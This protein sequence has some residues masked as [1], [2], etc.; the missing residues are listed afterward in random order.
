LLAV[1]AVLT[2]STS[3]ASALSVTV[4]SGDYLDKIA[5][6]HNTTWQVLHDK[7]TDIPDPNLIYPGQIIQIPELNEVVP[8]RVVEA[9][10]AVPEVKVAPTP[11]PVPETVIERPKTFSNVS[12]NGYDPGQC[13]WYVKNMRPDLPNNL[14]DA[15]EWY[16]NAQAQGLSVGEVPQAGAAAPRK[17]G[18]HVVYVHSVN[19]D[20]TITI[21]EMNYNWVKYETRTVNKPASDYYYIY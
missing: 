16:F 1:L 2:L 5:K 19:N 20:G 18:N 9:P 17:Y 4:K 15:N 21:S 7:N 14:G 6:E 10:V 11:T 13:T 8:P 3:S 12:G